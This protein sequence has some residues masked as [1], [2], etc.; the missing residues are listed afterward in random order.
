MCVTWILFFGPFLPGPLPG[1]ARGSPEVS[2]DVVRARAV[3]PPGA[4]PTRAGRPRAEATAEATRFWVSW[5]MLTAA[6]T[7]DSA[8]APKTK[9]A[10][11]GAA[12]EFETGGG[13]TTAGG[14]IAPTGSTLGMAATGGATATGGIPPAPGPGIS[15]IAPVAGAPSGRTARATAAMP[16]FSGGGATGGIGAPLGE[17]PSILIGGTGA[18]G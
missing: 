9:G 16:G 17:A 5:E 13:A 8:G 6:G 12:I 14:G 4:A 1:T 7:V 2:G 10:A 11:A 18:T 15:F 3:A